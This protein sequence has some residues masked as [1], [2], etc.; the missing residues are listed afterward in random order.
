MTVIYGDP[1]GLHA[2]SS[3][4][5]TQA[6]RPAWRG[7]PKA[8]DRFGR[9]LASGDFDGDGFADLAIGIPDEQLAGAGSPEGAVEVLFGSPTG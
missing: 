7:G 4:L 6:S 8:N 5:W 9:S 3:Q 2:A 1:K